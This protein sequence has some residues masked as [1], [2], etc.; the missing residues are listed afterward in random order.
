MYISVQLFRNNFMLIKNKKTNSF[1]L[2]LLKLYIRNIK[3]SLPSNGFFKFVI[4]LINQVYFLSLL[5]LLAISYCLMLLVLLFTAVEN[6]KKK[7]IKILTN[8]Y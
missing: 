4:V 5:L 2:S 3:Q 8:C 7:R 1:N 6:C